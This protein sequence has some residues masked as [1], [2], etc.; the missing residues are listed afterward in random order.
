MKTSVSL[1]AL[2]IV[3]GSVAALPAC[4]A[5]DDFVTNQSGSGTRHGSQA[6][7]AAAP[8]SSAPALPFGMSLQKVASGLDFPTAIDFYGG[9]LVVTEA[10][11][12]PGLTPKVKTI[13][14]SGKVTTLLSAGDLP[15]GAVLGPLTDVTFYDGYLWITHRQRGANDWAVGAISIFKPEDPVGTF[16]TVLTNLPSAG[17]HFTEE[18]AFDQA[19]RGY[20]S[21]G[22][23]TNTAVVGTDNAWLAAT[24]GFHDYPPVDIQVNGTTFRST[25]PLSRNGVAAV[26]APYSAF[27]TGGPGMGATV[28]APSPA[29]PIDGM[30]AGNGAIYSFDATPAA[31]CNPTT[32]L[33]LEAWGLRD[34]YGMAFD[35]KIPSTLYVSNNGSDIAMDTVNG[36]SVLR[37]S[38]PI[39]NDFDDLFSFNVGEATEFFGFPD[40]FHRPD[41]KRAIPVS[42]NFF[43]NTTEADIPCPS[44]ILDRAFQRT[45]AIEPAVSELALH[46][47]AGKL[48]FAPDE[49]ALSNDIFLA[50]T[51]AFVGRTGAQQFTGYKVVRIEKST[52][53]VTDFLVNPGETAAQV[54]DPSH[55]NKP[56]DVKFNGA[57]MYV[58]DFGAYEPGLDIARPGTGKVYQVGPVTC[59]SEGGAPADAGAAADAP[60][61]TEAAPTPT[62]AAPPAG[63]VTVSIPPNAMTLGPAAYGANPLVVTSGTTVTWVNNDSLPHTVTSDTGAFDSGIM[64]PGQSFSFTFTGSGTFPYH[65]TIHGAAAMSGTVQI[66]AGT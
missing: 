65:C 63:A 50:E 19:G 33:H 18:V 61:P 39:A 41:T 37:G 55:L 17:E 32:S 58:V 57:S 29:E 16:R 44:E 48:A 36:A 6:R 21:Q 34:A 46:A 5:F 24:P 47:S 15:A 2:S 27:N 56:I 1:A 28:K 14:A 26:T 64:Q 23:A 59:P 43:C 11:H 38:R 49:A 8:G 31:T 45:L 66:S 62:E 40:F 9:L 42:D 25:N 54:F 20:F 4:S 3:I 60:A 22:T 7:D 13:D 52:G 10:G 12:L 51:G 30:V 53:R 35:P